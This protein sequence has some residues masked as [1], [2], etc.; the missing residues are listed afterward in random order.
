MAKKRTGK[1]QA[2]KPTD[3]LLPKFSL[4]FFDRPRTTAILWLIVA[5]F[6]VLSYTTFLRREGFPTINIPL[7]I[8]NGSYAVNDASKVDS[9][10]AAKLGKI[11][12]QQDGANSVDVQSEANFFTAVVQYDEK[13]DAKSAKAD[14]ERAV[15]AAGTLPDGVELTYSAPYFGVTGGSTQKIDATVSLYADQQT[16]LQT[17]TKT[18]NDAVDYL[19]QRDYSQIQKFFVIDPFSQVTN[20]VTGQEIT[21][22]RTFDRYGSREDGSTD[23]ARSVVIGVAGVNGSDALKLDAEIRDALAQ[24][25]KTSMFDGYHAT[26]SATN[27]RA[28]NQSISELQRVLLEGLLAVLVVGSIVI[29]VRASFVTVISMLTVIATTLGLLY[30]IGFTL[31]VI[32]LF[33][34]ILGLSL[35]VDD[36]IIMIEAIDASRKREKDARTVVKEATRKISRAMVAAT[37]T[38]AL[39]FAPLLFVGGILGTFIRAIP[40]TIIAALLISLLVALVFIPFFARFALLGKKQLGKKSGVVEI[41]ADFEEKVATWLG[42][43]ML[44]ARHHRKREF[45]V[46]TSAVLIGVGFIVAAGFIFTKV[47]FNIFPPTKDTNQVAVALVFPPNTTVQQAEAVAD[48]ADSKTAQILGKYFEGASYYGMGSAQSATLYVD[49][50]SYEERTPTA[51]QLVEKLKAGFENFDGAKVD[52]YQ[53]DV[54][55]PNASLTVNINATDR[56]AAEKLAADMAAYLQGRKLTRTS[57]EVATIT[58]ANVG[59]TS[60]YHRVDNEPV[61][62]VTLAFDGDDTTTLTTLAQTAIEDKYD[63]QTLAQYNLKPSDVKVDLGE[64]QQNQ[65]SFKTLALAFPVLLFVIYLLLSLQFRSLLQPLLIFMAI[66]FSLFGV[67]LGLYLTDNAFS[68]FAMLGFFALIGLS[69]KNTILLTDY[70]NQSRRAGM[71]PIDAAVAALGER[72]RPLVATSLTAIFSLIPL[73]VVSPFWQGLAVVLI[74]GLASSTLLVLTVFPYYYL[75]AEY[76]RMKVSRGAFWK[77][78]I[79]NIVAVGLVAF[80]TKNVAVGLVTFALLNIALIAYQANVRRARV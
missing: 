3:K 72:F 52:A 16:D 68:F 45:A 66:P 40:M 33:A 25:D 74:F 29:A 49:L 35:I 17:L 76:L 1:Q 37:T 9:D 43:P 65:D 6:G 27:A 31:N 15:Q 79:L 62:G 32:T 12:L 26:V 30:L 77:W 8:V 75:G 48:R 10:V 11:A 4:F 71:G 51:P 61:I 69:I 70:A 22:Q 56:A 50:V 73:A 42:R 60:V 44:W 7:V 55:P 28:I 64:E 57:G 36:T 59:N 18:A 41:A 21:V 47:T 46:G 67:T 58:E 39:S 34:I 38:A 13:V 14:L 24:L 2:A 5:I 20:P 80:A 63:A 78:A 54:G 23:F 53:L 19:N